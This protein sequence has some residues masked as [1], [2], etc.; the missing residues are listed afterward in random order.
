MVENF[1]AKPYLRIYFTKEKDLWEYSRDVNTYHIYRF[2]NITRSLQEQQYIYNKTPVQ[3]LPTVRE[4]QR[5]TKQLKIYEVRSI[6]HEGKDS[7]SRYR[8]GRQHTTIVRWQRDGVPL[9]AYGI[10]RQQP[11]DSTVHRCADCFDR[12]SGRPPRA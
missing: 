2:N 6:Y 4:R 5:L 3:V 7:V 1:T 9:G 11:H 8:Y 10:G 12:T